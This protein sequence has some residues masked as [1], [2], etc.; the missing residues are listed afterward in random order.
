ML[1]HH[2]DHVHSHNECGSDTHSHTHDG[3]S[4]SICFFI[5]HNSV[6]LPDVPLQP[7]P[8]I[9]VCEVR[10]N[11]ERP[12]HHIPTPCLTQFNKGPPLY[13]TS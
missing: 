13:P 12:F 11:E 9:R 7:E 3:D 10:Q 2:H 5:Q 6:P 8:E 1:W 4:C